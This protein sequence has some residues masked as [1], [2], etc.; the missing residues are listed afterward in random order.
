MPTFAEL[1]AKAE[2]AANSAR[3][4]ANSRIADYRGDKKQEKPTYKPPP[5]RPAFRPALP[6]PTS[7]PKPAGYDVEQD[8]HDEEVQ[9]VVKVVK[10][11]GNPASRP[12]PPRPAS[13]P[14][15]PPPPINRPK[16]ARYD[17]E[18][19]PHDKEVQPVVIENRKPVGRAQVVNMVVQNVED[20]PNGIEALLQNKEQFFQF[21]DEVVISYLLR[22]EN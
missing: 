17:V 16:P 19:D 10:K 6:P 14:A 18:E 7:R 8:A 21:M 1:R 3:D 11:P 15:L 12:P 9:P 20:E 5:P 2:A 13:K 22:F 4:S